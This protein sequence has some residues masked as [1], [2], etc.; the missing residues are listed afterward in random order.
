MFHFFAHKLARLCAGR[1]TF[2]SVL[3][4]A[5]DCVL[6]WHNKDVSPLI[7]HLDV[8]DRIGLRCTPLI[9]TA[10]GAMK[11]AVATKPLL[12]RLRSN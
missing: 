8:Q 1:L 4:R 9:S 3:V 12:S 7:W 6:F 5:F 11:R 2:T 10:T